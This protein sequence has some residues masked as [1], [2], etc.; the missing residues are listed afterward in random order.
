M[1]LKSCLLANVRHP[2]TE[3]VYPVCACYSL[4]FGLKK[5]FLSVFSRAVKYK[6]L[7][8]GAAHLSI[9]PTYKRV[10]SAVVSIEMSSSTSSP[11]ILSQLIKTT[12]LPSVAISHGQDSIQLDCH[13]C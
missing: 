7:C 11:W 8:I 13:R 3:S 9:I 6:Y 5:G 10:P 12:T 1:H 2:G 4:Q